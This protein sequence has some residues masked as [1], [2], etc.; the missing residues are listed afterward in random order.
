MTTT[1]H[2]RTPPTV[3]RDSGMRLLLGAAVAA[4]VGG[5]AVAITGLVVSGA[6][7]LLGALTG[8]AL[9]VACFLLGAM[10][11]NLVASVMPAMSLLVALFTYLLQV[12][13]LLVVLTAVAGSGWGETLPRG[14]VSAA[15]IVATMCWMAGQ[16]LAFTRSRIPAYDVPRAGAR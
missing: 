4:L 16:V 1:E 14:W 10:V 13:G 3:T 5:S 12:L 2:R 7:A 8:T 15:I 9:V 6:D 11:V